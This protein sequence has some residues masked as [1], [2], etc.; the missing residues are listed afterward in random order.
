MADHEYPRA[1]Y[2]IET[3]GSCHAGFGIVRDGKVWAT[4]PSALY[5]GALIDALLRGADETDA[6]LIA[7]TIYHRPDPTLTER[8]VHFSTSGSWYPAANP[9]KRDKP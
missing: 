6:F 5:L 3:V 2:R 7:N 1:R 9:Y 8:L 4:H